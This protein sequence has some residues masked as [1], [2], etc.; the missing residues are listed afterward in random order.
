[1]LVRHSLRI[2]YHSLPIDIRF[3]GT[4]IF[5]RVHE[6]TYLLFILS[7]LECIL[8]REETSAI[9]SLADAIGQV[10]FAQRDRTV[11]ANIELSMA[12]RIVLDR[13]V[14][15]HEMAINEAKRLRGALVLHEER[16]SKQV[17]VN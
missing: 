14:H 2:H 1:M 11:Q 5:D 9:S 10:F 17:T 12:W 8:E 15:R 13:A 16:L 4:F 7:P 3:R 6:C